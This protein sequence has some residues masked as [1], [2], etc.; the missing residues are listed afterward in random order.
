MW[1]LSACLHQE[2]ILPNLKLASAI[3]PYTMDTTNLLQ[4]LA[5]GITHTAKEAKHQNK[6]Q[7]KHLDYIK[8]KDAR[9]KNKVEKWHH[10]SRCL[11]LN[12]ASIDSNS[13]AK[14]IPKSYLCII[15]SN[16]TKMADREL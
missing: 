14:E 3:P 9:K 13:P 2:H 12:P 1:V 8:E 4:S 10:T 11:V 5:A 16:T 15:N 6:I 7:C